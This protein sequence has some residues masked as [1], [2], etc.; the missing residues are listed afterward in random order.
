[1]INIKKS[2]L[3]LVN[4]LCGD[5]MINT[6]DIFQSYNIRKKEVA[7]IIGIFASPHIIHLHLFQIKI[8]KKDRKKSIRLIH[9]RR[10]HTKNDKGK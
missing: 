7:V 2:R 5:Q 8:K 3:I 10:I 9:N 4:A 1:M 6:K